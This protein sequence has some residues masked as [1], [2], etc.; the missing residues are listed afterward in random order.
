MNDVKNPEKGPGGLR[1]AE[2]IDQLKE[3]TDLS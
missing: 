2:Q 3:T 1:V